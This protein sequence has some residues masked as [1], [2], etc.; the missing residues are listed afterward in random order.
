MSRRGFILTSDERDDTLEALNTTE[1]LR[2]HADLTSEELV[3][4]TVA[5]AD[6]LHDFTDICIRARKPVQRKQHGWMLLEWPR[7]TANQCFLED[8]KPFLGRAGSTQA[9]A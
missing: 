4:M 1:H 3:E 5:E 7:Q 8:S 9:F 6:L 2:S